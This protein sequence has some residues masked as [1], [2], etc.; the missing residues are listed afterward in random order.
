AC[1][2][3]LTQHLGVLVFAVPLDVGQRGPRRNND[4]VAGQVQRWMLIVLFERQMVDATRTEG[5]GSLGAQDD[6][7]RV[8][9]ENLAVMHRLVVE[10]GQ[11]DLRGHPVLDRGG[12]L[13][14]RRGRRASWIFAVTNGGE[15]LGDP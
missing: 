13:I 11:V 4:V 7:V 10:A 5:R 2:N 15:V 9:G 1:P 8:A 14:E 12:P 3:E 6:P